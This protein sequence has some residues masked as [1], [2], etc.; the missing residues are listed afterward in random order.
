MKKTSFILFFLLLAATSAFSQYPAY[1]WPD[2]S[3]MGQYMSR[4]MN[5]LQNSDPD[6]KTTVR[7]LVYGQSI[8]AQDWWKDLK[9]DLETRFPNANIDMRN[10]SIGGF[11]S[12]VLWKTTYFDVLPFDPDLVLFHDYGGFANKEKITQ[13]IREHTA[14]E[15]LWRSSHFHQDDSN[16]DEEHNTLIP[17]ACVRNHLEFGSFRDEWNEY[18]ETNS[19][20]ATDLLSDAI[21]LNNHGKFLMAEI[22]KPYFYYHDKWDADP[23]TL[24]TEHT[25]G[26]EMEWDADTLLVD[27]YGN[28]CDLVFNNQLLENT[29]DTIYIYV[30]GK[31]PKEYKDIYTVTRPKKGSYNF[32]SIATPIRI[33][34]DNPLIEEEWTLTYRSVNDDYTNFTFDVEGSVTGFDGTGSKSEDFISNSGRVRIQKSDWWVFEAHKYFGANVYDGYQITWQVIAQGKNKFVPVQRNDNIENTETLFQGIPNSR[35]TLKLVFKGN[36]ECIKSVRAYRPLLNRKY[37]YNETFT[38]TTNANGNGNVFPQGTHTYNKGD[39]VRIFAEPDDGYQVHEWVGVDANGTYADVVMDANKSI[40]VNFGLP[41]YTLTTYITNGGTVKPAGKTLITQNETIMV[42]ATP[43]KGFEFKEWGGNIDD[44]YKTDDTVYIK[45]DRNKYLTPV[46]IDNRDTFVLTT[47]AS[48]GGTVT[49]DGE[50]EFLEGTEVQ[51]IAKPNQGY[52]FTGWQEYSEMSDTLV[53]SVDSTMTVYAIFSPVS[54]IPNNVIE[55]NNILVYPN[56]VKHVM[57]VKL[58]NTDFSNATF[59]ITTITGELV[60]NGLLKPEIDIS[61]LK[62]GIYL[63]SCRLKKQTITKQLIIE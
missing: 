24:M 55:N 51:I 11:Q 48:E 35:H 57:N 47:I 59:K 2:T 17:E 53:I 46:W 45:M 54:S 38:L 52:E 31:H 6:N 4:T 15:I 34:N 12:H 32:N 16:L 19:I 9:S 37:F 29:T 26:A 25:A 58:K 41:R 62:A 22:H 27:F 61:N 30:D 18:L 21:H 8:N 33:L 10:L 56:P 5:L 63:F 50:N 7:I 13:I 49:P 23:D 1:E 3:N 60:K 39:I 14:A 43:D 28:R 40:T 20:E 36:K 42:V 44:E